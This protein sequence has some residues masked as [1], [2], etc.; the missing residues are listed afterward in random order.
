RGAGGATPGRDAPP[1]AAVVEVAAAAA[2]PGAGRGLVD[3]HAVGDRVGDVLL[4]DDPSHIRRPR[5]A[6]AAHDDRHDRAL[7]PHPADDVEGDLVL[8]DHGEVAA[9][10]V[11]ERHPGVRGLEPTPDP[12]VDAD[13]AEDAALAGDHHVAQP[14]GVLRLAQIVVE[15]GFGRQHLHVAVHH[16]ARGLYQEHVGVARLR[17]R[18]P[19]AHELERVDG[20]A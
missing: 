9:G 6:V 12:G 1:G 14:S 13:D 18:P 8:A 19:P 16:V 10:D 5:H 4:G 15:A 2:P 11:A 3:P 20:L 7:A 17:D